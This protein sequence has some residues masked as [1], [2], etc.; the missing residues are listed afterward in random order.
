MNMRR[1]LI[2]ILLN[3]F[4]SSLALAQDCADFPGM[5]DNCQAYSCKETFQLTGEVLKKQ[6]FGLEGDKCHLIQQTPGG[7]KMECRL[8]E[9]Q[10]KGMAQQIRESVA[11]T[12]GG[13]DFSIKASG[14][15]NK[16]TVQSFGANGQEIKSKNVLQECV[17]S[18]ACV[19]S[20]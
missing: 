1:L 8:S 13:K 19:F 4:L 20:K 3:G 14:N 2:I 5:L 17:S 12:N 6:I 9:E 10:R 18:G 11:A 15:L 7:S 16:M